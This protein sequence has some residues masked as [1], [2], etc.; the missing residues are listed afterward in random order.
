MADSVFDTNIDT[1]ENQSGYQ[2]PSRHAVQ[3][4]DAGTQPVADVDVVEIND[5]INWGRANQSQMYRS[6]V[7]TQPVSDPDIGS[8][9][10]SDKGNTDTVD[11]GERDNGPIH[12]DKGS[13]G[14]VDVDTQSKVANLPVSDGDGSGFAVSDRDQTS[15]ASPSASGGLPSATLPVFTNDEIAHQLT[16]DFNTYWGSPYAYTA[17]AV[18]PGG[19]ITVDIDALNAPGQ[20]LALA[21]LDAW[22]AVTGIN[23][24]TVGS[25][26]MITFDDN[27][28]GYNAYGGRVTGSGTTTYTSEVMIT[29]GWIDLY[30]HG[31]N[32]YSFQT[33]MHEIGHALGLGHAGNY[34]GSA[35]YA[36]DGTGD[37][38]YLNDSWQASVMSYFDVNENTYIDADKLYLSTPMIADILAMQVLY[39]TATSLRTGD[40]VYGE[41]SAVGGY[42]GDA[43]DKDRAF[44]VIDNGGN[45]TINFRSVSGDQHVDLHDETIS[46]VGGWTGNMEIARGTVIENFLSGS[47]ND[48]VDGNEA[49]NLI[50]G[51]AGDDLINGFEGDDYLKGQQDDDEINGGDGDDR[52]YGNIGKDKLRGDDGKDVLKGGSGN[53]MLWGGDGAD[54]LIGGKGGDKLIGGAGADKFIFQVDSGID[55]IRDF[56]D[57]VDILR[58]NDSI[59]GGGLTEQQVIDTYGGHNAQ[60]WVTLDFGGG[61]RI[62]FQ[63]ITD[64]NDLVDDLVIF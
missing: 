58:L 34:N 62:V 36:E 26:A 19:T 35:S 64:A 54:K 50:R 61:D 4:W 32:S 48:T 20:T 2:N 12:K 40:T 52:L 45:D 24:S 7:V 39:G 63:G 33:Y 30:G 3:D 56:E 1:D 46:D 41:G 15:S 14:T 16:H 57:N 51:G 38:H 21:A 49:D 31:L 55:V 28:G 9:I 42:Y 59:W 23:F 27:A 5:S 60:G 10:I 53:D 17:F 43:I 29:T 6:D 22:T 8:S 11:V 18:A 47:G 13:T 44:T 37:N 25:G